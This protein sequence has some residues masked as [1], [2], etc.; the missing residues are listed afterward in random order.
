MDFMIKI[1]VAY[2]QAFRTDKPVVYK[3]ELEYKYDFYGY[4]SKK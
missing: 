1:E 4:H 3:G 2:Q